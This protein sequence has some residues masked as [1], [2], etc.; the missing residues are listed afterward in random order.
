MELK[1]KVFREVSKI[2]RGKTKTYKEIAKKLKT[3]PRAVA[4][5]LS[6]NKNP[7]KIPCHRVIRSDGKIGGYTFKGKFNPKM[8]IRL[9]KKEGLIAYKSRR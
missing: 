4:K 2:P 6:S 9:L 1:N 5:I 8:K 3:S 7:I